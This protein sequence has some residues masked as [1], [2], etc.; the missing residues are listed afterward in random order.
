MSKMSGLGDNFYVGG[1]ALSGDTNSVSNISGGPAAIDMT[2]IDKSAHERLGGLR[3]GNMQWTSYFNNANTTPFGAH[4][5]LAPLPRTDVGVMY[6]RG[7]ALGNPG[8]CVQGKQIDYAPSRGASGELTIKVEVQANGFGLEWGQQLTAGT[9]TDVAATNGTAVDFTTA[10]SFGFQAYL[11]VFAFTGTDVTIKLQDSADNSTFT[12]VASGAFPQVTV[13]RSTA[14]IAVGGTATV[15]RY[16]RAVTV[17][18]GGFTSVAFAVVL[19]KNP[20]AVV[21]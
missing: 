4:H 20:V 18:T 14:R 15:R 10:T 2:G 21:F 7:V 6:C 3:D 1:Y 13:G 12:D 16:V 5:A 19:A 8:A 9:R 11:Q 17:T